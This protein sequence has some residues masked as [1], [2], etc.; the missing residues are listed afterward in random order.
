MITELLEARKIVANFDKTIA[1]SPYKAEYIIERSNIPLATFYRKLRENKFTLDEVIT[2]VAIIHPEQYEFEMLSK[3]IAIAEEQFRNGQFIEH[4]D[5]VFSAT[6][7][8]A[9]RK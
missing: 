3:K 1:N 8:L 5:F 4:K 9:D 2:I 6:K 7:I